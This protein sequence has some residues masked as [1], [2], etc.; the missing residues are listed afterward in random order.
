MS[1]GH[2]RRQAL[3]RTVTSLHQYSLTYYAHFHEHRVSLSLSLARY[4]SPRDYRHLSIISRG[5]RGVSMVTA[6]R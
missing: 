5:V 4:Q 1:F 6:T 2:R 3:M